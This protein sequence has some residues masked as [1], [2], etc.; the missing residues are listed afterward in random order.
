MRICIVY[1]TTITLIGKTIVMII[2]KFV[3]QNC[4]LNDVINRKKT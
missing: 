1:S 3:R 2:P 4:K